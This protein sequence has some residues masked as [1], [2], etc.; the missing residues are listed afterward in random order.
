[1]LSQHVSR[2]GFGAS[3]DGG[4]VKRNAVEAAVA[5]LWTA[6]AVGLSPASDVHASGSAAILTDDAHTSASAAT[7]RLGSRT[8]LLTAASPESKTFLRFDLSQL[9]GGTTGAAI[10]RATLRIWINKVGSP[11]SIQFRRVDG[12]WDEESI[13]HGVA[14][15]LGIPFL[16]LSAPASLARSFL[17]ADITSLV[18]DWVDDV[19]PNYGLAIVSGGGSV[20]LTFDS[21]ENT[22]TGHECALEIELAPDA[23]AAGT[24]GA[25]GAAGLMGPAGETGA[26]GPTGPSGAVGPQGPSGL[27]GPPGLRGPS[28]DAGPPGATGVKGLSGPGGLMGAIGATGGSGATGAIGPPGTPGVA[29]RPGATGPIGADGPSGL[30]GATGAIGSKGPVGPVGSIGAPGPDGPVGPQARRVSRGAGASRESLERS[31]RKARR[32]PRRTSA[33]SERCAGTPPTRRT[34]SSRARARPQSRMTAR[35]SGSSTS[36]PTRSRRSSPGREPS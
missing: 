35:T 15:S 1:M 23:G 16:T 27:V 26:P 28:G 36:I 19:S 20:S 9:P 11:G 30:A 12:E 18:R 22:L 10:P 33:P 31:A 6:I 29:G 8:A 4:L 17:V 13:T 2:V 24:T 7:S 32:E 14:P 34:R 21:K 3:C 25:A 5:A